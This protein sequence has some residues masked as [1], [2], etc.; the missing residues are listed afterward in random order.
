MPRGLREGAAEEVSPPPLLLPLLPPPPES[1]TGLTLDLRTLS[2]C[3]LLP[4]M[5]T[6]AR[7]WEG[8]RPATSGGGGGG[9]GV[10]D[11]RCRREAGRGTA[12]LG[13]HRE[14]PGAMG[15]WPGLRSAPG[16]LGQPHL[17]PTAAAPDAG[18][19]PEPG[20]S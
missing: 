6:V 10:R 14:S 13:E 11:G 1:T 19:T 9:Q 17:C 18:A 20:S 3:Y 16:T 2:T 4:G 12:R 5:Q 15:R 7:P 8:D